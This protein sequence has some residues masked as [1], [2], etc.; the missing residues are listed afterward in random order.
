MHGERVPG[1]DRVGQHATGARQDLVGGHDGGEH[2][3]SGRRGLLAGGERDRDDRG[4]GVREERPV[5]PLEDL[6][7]VGVRHRRVAHRGAEA[8]LPD[9]GAG[10]ALAPRPDR[11]RGLDPGPHDGAAVGRAEDRGELLLRARDRP[12]REVREAEPVHPLGQH[13]RHARRARRREDERADL[14]LGVVQEVVQGLE[15]RR[16]AL[17]CG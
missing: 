8:R 11:L 12:R 13:P 10:A 6:G 14:P 7:E 15:R 5:L 4:A 16:L 17:A 2:V 9:H 1:V 3:A